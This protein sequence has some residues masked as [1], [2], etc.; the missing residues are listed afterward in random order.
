M[1]FESGNAPDPCAL[2][3]RGAVTDRRQG[4]AGLAQSSNRPN[5]FLHPE[6]HTSLVSD[7]NGR[8]LGE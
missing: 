5:A 7:Q 8:C 2:G 4:R 3:R 1:R 6:P